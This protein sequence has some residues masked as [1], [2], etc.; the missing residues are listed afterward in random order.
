MDVQAAVQ[1]RDKE[2]KLELVVKNLV[3]RVQMNT[4]LIWIPPV[5]WIGVPLLGKVAQQSGPENNVVKDG[6]V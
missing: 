1:R 4:R 5:L 3:L 2:W 6:I